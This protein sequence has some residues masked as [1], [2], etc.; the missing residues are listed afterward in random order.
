MIQKTN[1]LR[2][3]DFEKYEI[4]L[5]F[6]AVLGKRRKKYLYSELE[7]MHP[8]FSDEFCFDT[9]VRKIG[10]KG[11]ST[12]V[13][14]MSKRKLAEYEGKR[15]FSGTGFFAG[16]QKHRFFVNEKMRF[17]FL[18]LIFCLLA[19]C[20]IFLCGKIDEH[21][22]VFEVETVVSDSI[23]ISEEPDFVPLCNLFFVVL[24]KSG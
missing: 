24:N 5:P 1:V 4:V 16:K 14:V 9:A 11:I 2:K 7:K 3:D 23:V 17:I 20:V 18:S 13:L 6:S 10:K 15:N 22:T 21:E 12:D 8:C 19:W